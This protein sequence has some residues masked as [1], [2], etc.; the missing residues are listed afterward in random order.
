MFESRWVGHVEIDLLTLID[1][2]NKHEEHL[3]NKQ[4][5]TND[6]TNDESRRTNKERVFVNISEKERE[7]WKQQTKNTARTYLMGKNR[8]ASA[9]TWKV[10]L[11]EKQHL[12]QVKHLGGYTR[13]SEIVGIFSIDI[14]GIYAFCILMKISIISNGKY[15]IT[16][17]TRNKKRNARVFSLVPYF[18]D[19]SCIWGD[20]IVC[21][22][23]RLRLYT[24][25][26]CYKMRFCAKE[27]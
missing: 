18:F 3:F 11:A 15:T 21:F 7:K 14:I 24:R 22:F 5:V 23:Y 1:K 4:F 16:G 2:L 10:I 6:K 8:V 27:K 13:L 26:A 17:W 9:G 25:F 12:R 19:P 20:E